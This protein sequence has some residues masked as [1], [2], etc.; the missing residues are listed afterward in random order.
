MVW[1][2]Y[3]VIEWIK[4]HQLLHQQ[5]SKF[6]DNKKF[7]LQISNGCSLVFHATMSL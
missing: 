1:R 4:P 5:F 2:V 7:G 3:R 6:E